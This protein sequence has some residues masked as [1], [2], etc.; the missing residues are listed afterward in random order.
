MRKTDY[1]FYHSTFTNRDTYSPLLLSTVGVSWHHDSSRR[2]LYIISKELNNNNQAPITHIAFRL[3]IAIS[4]CRCF[5]HIGTSWSSAV[6]VLCVCVCVMLPASDHS[7]LLRYGTAHAH[8]RA[9]M[10]GMISLNV[11]Y[12]IRGDHW[13]QFTH[14]VIK[15]FH[16]PVFNALKRTRDPRMVNLLLHVCCDRIIFATDPFYLFTLSYVGAIVNS[17]RP[18]CLMSVNV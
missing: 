3:C 2:Q 17:D 7:L 12:L 11:K 15:A 6:C 1:V 14:D 5:N 9:A 4:N 8:I 18:T 16:H 13:Q 10:N